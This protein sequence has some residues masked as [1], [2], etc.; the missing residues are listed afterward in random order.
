MTSSVRA[1]DAMS[2]VSFPRELTGLHTR[3]GSWSGGV[4]SALSAAFAQSA[5]KTLLDLGDH[6]PAQARDDAE[7]TGSRP[8]PG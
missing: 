2:A 3:L 8:P 6:R 4:S 7:I 5:A 1:A